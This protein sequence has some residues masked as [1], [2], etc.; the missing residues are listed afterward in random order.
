M[1]VAEL[2]GSLLD[3]WVARAAGHDMIAIDAAGTCSYVKPELGLQV[4]TIFSPT[5]RWD[6]GGPIIER[7]RISI[8]QD[9]RGGCY[10]YFDHSNPTAAGP[11]ALVAAM[12]VYVKSKF[13]EEVDDI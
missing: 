3:Y 9:A 11:T 13:G 4:R 8:K 6:Q 5:S 1:R 2:E 7:E 12:R 10:A